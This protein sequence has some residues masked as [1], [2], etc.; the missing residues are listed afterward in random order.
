MNASVRR[1]PDE[2]DVGAFAQQV[3]DAADVVLVPV[4]QDDRLDLV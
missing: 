3:G 4:G 1:E 2:W